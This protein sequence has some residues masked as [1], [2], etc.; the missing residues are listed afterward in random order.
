MNSIKESNPTQLLPNN[1]VPLDFTSILTLPDSHAWTTPPSLDPLTSQDDS[2]IPVIDLNGPNALILI[3]EASENW[4]M[5]QVTNHDIPIHLFHHIEGQTR[6]L[7]GLPSTQK[8]LAARSP[9]G[10]TGYGRARI[11][12]FFTREMWY[13]GFTIMGSPAEHAS[14]LWPNQDTSFCNVM[15][16]C[17]KEMKGLSER[18]IGIMF[19]SLGLNEEDVKFLG[20]KDGSQYPQ[21][22]LQLNSYPKCPDPDR[23]MG[24]APHTDSSLITVLHQGGV[25]GLQ[26]F[27]EGIGWVSVSPVD[28]ALVVN[29]GDLMH[30]ISN[31]RFKCA[32]HQAVVNKTRH[33]I[34]V[35]YFYGPPGDV[36]ISPLMQ[37]VDFD[38]PVLYCPVTWK[39]YLDA[40]AIYFDKALDFIKNDK[41]ICQQQ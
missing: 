30:I 8:L 27:K 17:Q 3:K 10:L 21:G 33:R 15:E 23:A 19:K 16:A 11:S 28:D 9:G 35:A 2:I 37:L 20:L 24:L 6:C 4:G 25:S 39:E 1:I 34:S 5:F 12:D 31:G 36:K 32:Q 26:V 41:S 22:A 38:H 7:F 14:Q 40:K 18:I 13:E 29:I